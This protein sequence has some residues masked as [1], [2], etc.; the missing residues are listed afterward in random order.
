M[1][2]IQIIPLILSL[3][4]FSCATRKVVQKPIIIDQVVNL[5][6][7]NVTPEKSKDQ[8]ADL[9]NELPIYNPSYKKEIDLIHT[10][11]DIRFDWAKEELIGS[12]ELTC[13]AYFYPVKRFRLDAKGF[14]IRSVSIAG[15]ALNY[16]YDNENLYVNLDKTYN[17]KEKFTLQ[18]DY[19]ARPNEIPAGGSEAITSEKGLFFIDPQGTDPDKPTQIWTQ[20]ETQSNSRWFPTIDRPNERCTEEILLTVENKYKTLSNGIMVSSKDNKDGTRTDHWMLDKPHAPYLFMIAVGEYSINYDKWRD[21]PLAYYVEPEYAADAKLIFNNTPE[22]LEF[23]STRLGVKYQWPSLSQIIVRDYVSGAME[24]TTAIVYGEPQQRHADELK[25][26]P[27][28]DILAHEIFHH[29]FGDYVTCESW[30]NLPLNEGFANYAE[31]LWSEHKYGYNEAEIHRISEMEGYLASTAYNVHPLINYAYKHETEMFDAHS[32]NKGGLVLHMLRKTVGDDAFFA[33]LQRY[34]EKNALTPV[35][36]DNLR[37]AFEEVTGQDMKWFFDEWYFAAGHPKLKIKKEYDDTSK[38]LAITIEQEQTGEKIPHIFQFPLTIDIYDASGKLTKYERWVNERIQNF[39]FT[40]PGGF[41]A[42]N[43]DPERILVCE[44][45]EEMT[46]EESTA[47]YKLNPPIYSRLGTIKSLADK[48][49]KSNSIKEILKAALWDSDKYIRIIG[50]TSSDT[51]NPAVMTRIKELSLKDSSEY[52]RKEAIAIISERDEN[53]LLQHTSEYLSIGSAEQKAMVLSAL[54]QSNPEKGLEY[55]SKY[56]SSSDVKI[57]SV[58]ASI[59]SREGKTDKLSWLENKLK[60]FSSLEAISI[61]GNYALLL[62][63]ADHPTQKA[64][65]D[66]LEKTATDMSVSKFKRFGAGAAIFQVM[67]IK[68]Y[69]PKGIAEADKPLLE[70]LKSRISRIKLAETDTDIKEAYSRFR[71]D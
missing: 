30:A 7:I 29:W 46:V 66:S 28:D 31:Y 61:M 11:L 18:I 71:L 8:V 3:V 27:N 54:Y 12:A 15:K 1:K 41:I 13:K 9:P 58:L 59:Y 19:I 17:A 51:S 38:V 20:G 40:M 24:N 45:K 2:K 6:T 16:D 44:R 60:S 26:E 55:A 23:F 52:V 57:V 39:E 68:T 49:D 62:A 53:F 42:A 47:L 67:A 5:D 43:I 70:E 22:I 34:L 4:L 14:I 48:K 64:G 33:S 35:E 63:K 65:F 50:I 69:S 25:E 21:I 56:E 37:Q 10:K 32:Y 36:A